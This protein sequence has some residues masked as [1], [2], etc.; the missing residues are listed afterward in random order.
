V[1]HQKIYNQIITR[2]R[3]EM[4]LKN[5]D[6]YYEQ[7]HIIPK[8]LGGKNNK[9]NLVL[10]TAREHYIAHKLLCEIYPNNE[11]LQYALW[12]MMNLNNKNQKRIYHISSRDYDYVRNIHSN[13]MKRPKTNEF[14][15]KISESWTNERKQ[16]AGVLLA[17]KNKLR[18]GDKHPFFGKTRPEHSEWLKENHPMKGKTHSDETKNKIRKSLEQT[19]LKKLGDQNG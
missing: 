10:L 18:I 8:S 15:Q 16:Q 4:R 1:D 19:R 9:E 7:H 17:E 5:T 2:A 6:M 3:N 12:A 11:K 13:I 14:K